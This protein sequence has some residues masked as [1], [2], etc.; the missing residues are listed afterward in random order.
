MPHYGCFFRH[1]VVGFT[2][3][4]GVRVV[5]ADVLEQVLGGEVD[6][7]IERVRH[8]MRVGDSMLLP[9]FTPHSVYAPKRVRLLRTKLNV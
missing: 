9:P 8:H 3:F 4:E 1:W 7:T 5:H 2:N 6:F